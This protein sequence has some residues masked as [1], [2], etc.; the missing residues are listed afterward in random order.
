MLNTDSIKDVLGDIVMPRPIV[1]L[2]LALRRWL[3]LLVVLGMGMLG[4]SLVFNILFYI[5][6][7]GQVLPQHTKALPGLTIVHPRKLLYSSEP[8]SV[9]LASNP[10]SSQPFE[11]RLKAAEG[12]LVTPSQTLVFT[13]T[14]DVHQTYQFQLSNDIAV[15]KQAIL[16]FS[17]TVPGIDP[18]ITVQIAKESYRSSLWR[19]VFVIRSFSDGIIPV[20]IPILLFI[21]ST[22]IQKEQ[23]CVRETVKEFRAKL[24]SMELDAVVRAEF[25]QLKDRLYYLPQA[26]SQELYTFMGLS[27]EEHL[28]QAIKASSDPNW[29]NQHLYRAI[30]SNNKQVAQRLYKMQREQAIQLTEEQRGRVTRIAHLTTARPALVFSH[31]TSEHSM[32]E[33]A[34]IRAEY[35]DAQNFSVEALPVEHQPETLWSKL[36][37]QPV[38]IYGEAGS[39]K[40]ALLVQLM[41]YS[42][43][44]EPEAP[45]PLRI[46]MTES[47]VDAHS[48]QLRVGQV[49][50][51][52]AL[53]CLCHN[54][55]YWVYLPAE[56]QRQLVQLAYIWDLQS[57]LQALKTCLR[58][59]KRATTDF[60]D[61]E[62]IG[63]RD[64]LASGYIPVQRRLEW[65]IKLIKELNFDRLLICFDDTPGEIDPLILRQHLQQ[66]QLP[67]LLAVAYRAD[68]AA[69][70]Q[71]AN[72]ALYRVALSWT[73]E[74][75][76]QVL[77][78]RT[79][80]ASTGSPFPEEVKQ[81]LLQVVYTPRDFWPWWC[82]LTADQQNGYDIMPEEWEAI[83]PFMHAARQERDPQPLAF[84]TMDDC[85][86][87]IKRRKI[88]RERAPQ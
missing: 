62:T 5:F 22:F 13:F 26:E 61:L 12:A 70:R 8:Y 56:S 40:T 86:A 43:E 44:G 71:A 58:E 76:K 35:D 39:G 59:D 87:A 69:P 54:V 77:D 21:L 42:Q 74:Q 11:V 75:L 83:A 29:R 80:T 55:N 14:G 10:A 57:R 50:I 81:K 36:A 6:Q 48:L 72:N 53:L 82:V 66:L 68:V 30:M 9:T 84:W 25:Q 28:N 7:V 52:Q 60:D 41:H 27:P 18:N 23:N 34:A 38:A 67:I 85:A 20:I 51:E 4:C 49:L 19:D 24:A 15:N 46:V 32:F 47:L 79:M 17:H 63:Q 3:W 45:F 78:H 37:A 88:H 2:I 31:T 16:T 65:A 73:A 1:W 33:P 64:F